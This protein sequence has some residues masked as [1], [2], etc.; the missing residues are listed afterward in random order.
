MSKLEKFLEDWRS[1][2]PSTG[3]NK[4]AKLFDGVLEIELS[5][6]GRDDNT[7]RVNSI[8]SLSSG[9]RKLG[10]F[11]NWLTKKADSGGFQLSLAAQPFGWNREE[12]PSKDKIKFYME[13]FNFQVKYEYPD[14]EGYEMVRQP[15]N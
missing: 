6:S 10:K 13:R 9:S 1:F 4:R 15:K 8:H 14:E 11:M 7:I 3:L 5:K 2:T 12:L